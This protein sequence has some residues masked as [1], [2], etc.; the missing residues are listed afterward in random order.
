MDAT[1]EPS[2]WHKHLGIACA[3]LAIFA[4]NVWIAWETCEWSWVTRSGTLIVAAGVLLESWLILKTSQN[5]DMP[6]FGSQ[7]GHTAIRVAVVIVCLGTVVQGY[8]D[9]LSRILPACR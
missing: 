7:S 4:V 2:H 5:G 8:G 9:F 3:C 1:A 6:F